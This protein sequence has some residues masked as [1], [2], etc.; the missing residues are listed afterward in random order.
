[1]DWLDEALCKGKHSD[2]W[3][4]PLSGERSEPEDRYFTIAKMVCEHCPVIRECR[5]L[6]KDED[7]GVWGMTTPQERQR[8]QRPSYP[9]Y[10]LIPRYIDKVPAHDPNVQVDVVE[11]LS[12]LKRYSDRREQ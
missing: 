3:F 9:E 1:M 7:W 6:G 4:P 5:E 8:G 2:L 12:T 11:L 10:K